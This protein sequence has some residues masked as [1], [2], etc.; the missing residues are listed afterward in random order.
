MN[1]ALPL[2]FSSMHGILQAAVENERL[3]LTSDGEGDTGTYLA[4]GR[5]LFQLPLHESFVI[6]EVDDHLLATHDMTL[7]GLHFLHIDYVIKEK[8]T[9]TYTKII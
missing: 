8:M 7:F 9:K 4:V 5:Y 6:R 2:P 1:V 3:Y